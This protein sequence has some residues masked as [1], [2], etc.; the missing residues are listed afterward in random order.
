M[1]KNLSDAY[2]KLIPNIDLSTDISDR[3][4][5]PFDISPVTFDIDPDEFAPNRAANSAERIVELLEQ[6]QKASK[7]ESIKTTIILIISAL[8]LVATL[9]GIFR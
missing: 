1:D 7:C 3:L 8:T 5:K 9:V 4:V 6:N 2:K